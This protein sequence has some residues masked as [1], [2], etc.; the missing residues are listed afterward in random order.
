MIYIIYGAPCSG[1]STYI[2]NH[3]K[4]GDLICDVDLI[5]SAISVDQPHEAD[6][7]IH[8]IALK[9]KECLFDIIENRAGKWND[10]YI[11]SIANNDKDLQALK[12]RV[13]ADKLILIDTPYEECIKR[14][15]ERPDYFKLLINEWFDK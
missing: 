6:L 11:T 1:K 12:E 2:K 8:E 9:L 10:V 13:N 7:Y 4:E 3:A 14:S 15:F 5:Y